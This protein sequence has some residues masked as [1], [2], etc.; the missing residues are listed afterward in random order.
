VATKKP[1]QGGLLR[2]STIATP[3]PSVADCTQKGTLSGDVTTKVAARTKEQQN[4][5]A[6]EPTFPAPE[7]APLDLG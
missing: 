1:A 3:S 7:L 5:P 4:R 2:R 6:K